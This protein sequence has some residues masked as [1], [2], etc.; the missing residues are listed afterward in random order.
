MLFKTFS[1]V[2][3][4]RHTRI[5]R[6]E[7]ASSPAPFP[8]ISFSSRSTEGSTPK[9]WKLEAPPGAARRRPKGWVAASTC[10]AAR[11]PSGGVG[12]DEGEALVRVFLG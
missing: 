8:T 9:A 1:M 12:I 11:R 10:S 7:T 6:G 2:I 4:R 3:T 5:D